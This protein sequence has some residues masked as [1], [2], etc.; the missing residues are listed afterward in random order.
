MRIMVTLFTL[1]SISFS[2][3]AGVTATDGINALFSTRTPTCENY[4]TEFTLTD[5]R[6][7]EVA[8]ELVAECKVLTRVH[9]DNQLLIQDVA[10]RTDSGPM[11]IV[12]VSLWSGHQGLILGVITNHWWAGSGWSTIYHLNL[13]GVHSDETNLLGKVFLGGEG[14]GYSTLASY[15]IDDS[16]HFGL[17]VTYQKDTSDFHLIKKLTCYEPDKLDYRFTVDLEQGNLDCN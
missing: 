17:N 3:A 12:G 11:S 8:H 14:R 1:F 13:Y 7:I 15:G 9:I 6:K 10:Q 4:S 2:A 16:N 5:K